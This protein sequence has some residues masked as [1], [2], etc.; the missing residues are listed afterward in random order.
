MGKNYRQLIPLE[1]L[2]IIG[3]RGQ[4]GVKG[5]TGV[6]GVPGKP[7]ERGE[8]GLTGAKGERGLTGAKGERGLTGNRGNKGLPGE[9]GKSGERGLTG[10]K[11]ERGPRGERGP[12]GKEGKDGKDALKTKVVKDI[13][14]SRERSKIILGVKYTDGTDKDITINQ[15]GDVA[16]VGG[17]GN[18]TT[19][20]LP[21][22]TILYLASIAPSTATYQGN[23]LQ[24][25]TYSDFQGITNH[26]KALT[27][28]GNS[29]TDT[30][31][32]FTYS[33]KT[34]T[35]DVTL[36]YAAGV[37]QSKSITITKV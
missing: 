21:E 32:I 30:Q 37:W 33:N 14:A 28:S 29:L 17:S 2:P 8:T 35:I 26:T 25:I 12:K 16:F 18:T 24:T 13:V 3:P 4:R 5:K 7:G 9:R 20:N 6:V 1:N 31:E 36:T 22:D 15:K 10:A 19:S 27:Y 23:K 11:G 34:W